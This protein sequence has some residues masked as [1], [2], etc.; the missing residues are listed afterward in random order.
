MSGKANRL[1]LGAVTAWCAAVLLACSGDPTNFLS[2]DPANFSSEGTL[3]SPVDLG[4]APVTQSGTVAA[5]GSSYFSSTADAGMW[6]VGVSNIDGDP[7]LF[8][9]DDSAYTS[10]VDSSENSGADPE[11]STVD[12]PAPCEI[13]IRIFGAGNSGASFNLT[14]SPSAQ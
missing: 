5:A 12:C 6:L 13:Y 9:Y 8:L 7:D 1:A 14:I 4:A 11:A 3:N 10:L 2:G